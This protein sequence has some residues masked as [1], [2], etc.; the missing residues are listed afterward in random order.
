[1]T[2]RLEAVAHAL[3]DLHT[4]VEAHVAEAASLVNEAERAERLT[5]NSQAQYAR[6]CELIARAD[7]LRQAATDQ[8]AAL[9]KLRASISE[10][11]RSVQ[12]EARPT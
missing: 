1:M 7:S 2:R 6:L 9:E 11:R 3:V 12:L 8:R 10:L 5:K 4:K